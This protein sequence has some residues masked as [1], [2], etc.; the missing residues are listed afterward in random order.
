M[1]TW[2]C[3]HCRIKHEIGP[4]RGERILCEKHIDGKPCLRKEWAVSNPYHG[5]VT[6]GVEEVLEP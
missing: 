6:M 2:T 3:P 1:K 5:T 4:A